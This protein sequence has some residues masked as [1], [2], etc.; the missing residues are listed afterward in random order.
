MTDK[1]HALADSLGVEVVWHRH[2]PKG[3]W[4]PGPRMITLREGMGW[5]KERSTLAHELGHAIHNDLPTTDR[6]LHAR[7]EDRADAFAVRLL[8][9]PDEYAAAEAIHGPHTGALAVEL[10]ITNHLI[11]A[12]RRLHERI[13][14]S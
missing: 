2:G 9:T 11:G 1:L 13:T 3:L 14:T 12:A 10:G 8:I 7:Q 6:R 5:R 4:N